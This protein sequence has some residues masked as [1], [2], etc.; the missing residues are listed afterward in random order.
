MQ[1]GSIGQREE[2]SDTFAWWFQKAIIAAFS[3]L[4]SNVLG[5]IACT[6][7]VATVE[8]ELEAARAVVAKAGEARAVGEW[9]E[10]TTVVAVRGA[11]G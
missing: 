3:A 10:A 5:R 9:E 4:T 1:A 6:C 7:L 8:E 2:L 11:G